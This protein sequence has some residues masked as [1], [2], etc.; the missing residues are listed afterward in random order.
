MFLTPA[1]RDLTQRLYVEVRDALAP[2]LGRLRP[3]QR[4][5]LLG[6]LEPLLDPAAAR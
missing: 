6:L 5:Q 4:V 2:E 3:E 1:G